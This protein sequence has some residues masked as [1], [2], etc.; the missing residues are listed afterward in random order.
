MKDFYQ[1]IVTYPGR[2]IEVNV[3]VLDIESG[4]NCDKDF[5][6]VFDGDTADA[7]ILKTYCSDTSHDTATIISSRN[8]LYLYFK[9]DRDNDGKGFKISWKAII[10]AV[11]GPGTMITPIISTNVIT[12]MTTMK[13]TELGTTSKPEG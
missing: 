5:L 4:S 8:S 7:P 11:T 13:A 2:I 10:P 1:R 6:K 3:D 12:T 9:A